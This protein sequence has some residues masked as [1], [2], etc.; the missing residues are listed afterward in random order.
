MMAQ[1]ETKAND[2]FRNYKANITLKMS[3]IQNMQRKEA[4][5][6]QKQLQSIQ[7]DLLKNLYENIPRDQWKEEFPL[8]EP[9]MK[10]TLYNRTGLDTESLDVAFSVLKLDQDPEY[11]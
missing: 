11:I 6:L 1:V 7:L 5:A 4:L 10:D 9:M 8:I 2:Y 3:N